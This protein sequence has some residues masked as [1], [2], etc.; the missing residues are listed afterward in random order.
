LTIIGASQC[1]DVALPTRICRKRTA[2]PCDGASWGAA[3][4]ATRDERPGLALPS[5]RRSRPLGCC[6]HL[7][8]RV[9]PLGIE[10]VGRAHPRGY[11]RGFCIGR[12][13]RTA[14]FTIRSG[15]SAAVAACRVPP[16]RTRSVRLSAFR[17][18]FSPLLLLLVACAETPSRQSRA[19]PG[20]ERAID[21]SRGLQAPEYG[22][23]QRGAWIGGLVL[24]S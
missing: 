17:W 16:A 21:E 3:D 18:A 14:A 7:L 19:M 2:I 10:K 13:R 9:R 1:L 11:P 6:H 12:C 23:S 24:R 22:A 8:R 5:A 20:G 15:N 4:C